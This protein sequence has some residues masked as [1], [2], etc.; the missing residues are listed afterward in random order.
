MEWNWVGDLPPE[1]LR[2]AHAILDEIRGQIAL[3]REHLVIS[4]LGDHDVGIGQEDWVARA[5]MQVVE[6]LLKNGVLRAAERFHSRDSH[7]TGSERE[8]IRVEAAPDIVREGFK[9][10]D[11]ELF[12]KE[13]SGRPGRRGDKVFIGHGHSDVW[14][15]LKDFLHDRL[16]LGW[17]E[18]NHTSA[19]GIPTAVQ[20]QKCLEEARFAFLVMT[21]E[22][23]YPDGLHARE[24]V[25]HEIGLFQGHLGFGK[26]IVLLEEGCR[27]FSNI[28]GLGQIRFDKGTIEAKTEEIRKVL[29]REGI[30]EPGKGR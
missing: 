18:F 27:E 24:N 3:R 16:G 21:G 11:E 19:A 30:I 29:E 14:K 8:G 20:L 13:S 28:H 26:A 17:N 2:E 5:R 15:Q 25:I 4:L 23:E 10:L 1:I 6:M 12:G 7:L 9:R 22:D